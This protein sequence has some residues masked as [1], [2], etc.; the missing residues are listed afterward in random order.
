MQILLKALNSNQHIIKAM[1]II[2]IIIIWYCLGN[3]DKK[4][5]HKLS[6]HIPIFLR[7]VFLFLLLFIHIYFSR[8]G[9]AWPC[10]SAQYG[11]EKATC[12][13]SFSPPTM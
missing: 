13:S 1:W 11:G 4:V 8:E 6:T 9:D 7:V 2:I 5:L 12:R 3:N 10:H